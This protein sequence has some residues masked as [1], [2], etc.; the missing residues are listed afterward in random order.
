MKKDMK[1]NRYLVGMIVL[2]L[3]MIFGVI[4][5]GISKNSSP[6]DQVI[7]IGAIY[8]LS[9]PFSDFGIEYQRG[10]ELASN[11][12]NESGG[13]N[14]K[15][16]KLVFEDDKGEPKESINAINK[17]IHVDKIN[18]VFTGFATISEATSPI[19]QENKVLY[20]TA[21]VSKVGNGEY[22]FRHYWDIEAQGAA[23]GK[24]IN[25][26]NLKRIGI[27]AVNDASTIAFV[28]KMKE[29]TPSVVYFE[30]R[31][32]FGDLDFKTQLLKIKNA[33][34]DGILVYG[35]PGA[36]I[37]KITQQI[38]ELRLDNKRLFSNSVYSFPFIYTQFS[39][40]LNDMQ[41][42]DS[43]YALDSSNIKSVEFIEKYKSKYNQDLM[44]DAA[45]SYDSLYA[46][47]IAIENAGTHTDTLKV[48][49]ALRKVSMVGATGPLTFD[50]L[51]NSI[52]PAY[53]QTYKQN[54]WVKYNYE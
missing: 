3:I 1:K 18:Y 9:G 8:P 16:I 12:I 19:A 2:V 14:G 32:D 28:N 33:N 5:I 50:S 41:V 53:L 47:K 6:E 24:A 23:T 54:N 36:E 43:W 7:K 22:I 13:V 35:A 37:I 10:L 26:E 34:V 44:G 30:E 38:K 45:Y 25:K 20:I 4:A 27:I 49:N 52:S 17:L 42:I 21:A 48:A 29:E 51:G 31:Y 15:K 40:I 39:D 11:E 46:L